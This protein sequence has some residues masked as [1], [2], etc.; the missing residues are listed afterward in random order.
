MNLYFSNLARVLDKHK[1]EVRKILNLNETEVTSVQNPKGI[2][3]VKRT[4]KTGSITS[5]DRGQLVTVVYLICANGNV[6]PT[7]LIFS[8]K[9]YVTVLYVVVHKVA[10]EKQIY[11]AE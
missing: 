11:Q 7:M 1:F 4:R 10:L 5:A 3:T 2:V 6:V 9:N 8:G